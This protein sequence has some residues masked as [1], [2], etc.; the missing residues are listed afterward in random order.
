MYI[1]LFIHIPSPS[2]AYTL[3][4]F[5]PTS[6]HTHCMFSLTRGQLLVPGNIAHIYLLYEGISKDRRKHF[7][8]LSEQIGGKGKY[9]QKTKSPEWHR[10]A[11]C[12]YLPEIKFSTPSLTQ[13]ELSSCS[14]PGKHS[15]ARSAIFKRCP[16]INEK[17]RG[18]A[19]EKRGKLSS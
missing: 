19:V 1:S 5:K 7:I 10:N 11:Q 9:R 12:P 17:M 14:C 13:D 2:E 4:A 8:F 3:Y 16:R 15:T 6:K 18:T